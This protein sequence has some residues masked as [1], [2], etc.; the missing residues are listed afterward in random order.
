MNTRVREVMTEKVVT[1]TPNT[2]FKSIARLL[3]H[4]RV[5]LLPVID[6]EHRVVGVVTEADLL[7]KVEWQGKRPGRIERWLLLDD[8]LRKAEG[9]L[10]SQIMTRDLETTRPET[11][12]NHAAQQMMVSHV[13]ALPVVDENQRLV[14]IVSRADLLR[15]FIREDAAIHRE[16]I[17]EV[18]RGALSIDPA[19]VSVVVKDGAVF[20]KGEVESVSLRDMIT[21]MAGA[22]PGVVSVF[23][24][25]DARLDDRHLKAV[26]EPAD[27][28]TYAGPPLR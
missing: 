25:I 14:G 21:A 6:D 7:S 4:H 28:L 2:D 1:I 15:S 18:L 13:K 22:A 24:T 20:L 3:E 10:A 17:D 5:N 19:T 11:S 27:D 8:E 16:V 9:T 23:S 12:V 26:H